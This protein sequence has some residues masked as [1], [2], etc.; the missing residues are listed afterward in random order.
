MFKEFFNKFKR[1]TTPKVEMQT[2]TLYFI[3]STPQLKGDGLSG[4]KEYEQEALSIQDKYICFGYTMGAEQ[5]M[6][7]FFSEVESTE[8]ENVSVVRFMH[9]ATPKILEHCVRNLTDEAKKEEAKNLSNFKTKCNEISDFAVY[10]EEDWF[11]T[12]NRL[13]NYIALYVENESEGENC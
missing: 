9:C 3:D 7:K 2:H 11:S 8:N 12:I 1:K 5:E 6:P 4:I 10:Q 13:V